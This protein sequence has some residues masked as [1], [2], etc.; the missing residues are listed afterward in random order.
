MVKGKRKLG[1]KSEEAYWS[2]LYH[3]PSFFLR[4]RNWLN[5]VLESYYYFDLR[6]VLSNVPFKKDEKILEI[7]C[8]PGGF[9]VFFHRKYGVQVEGVDYSKAG[10]AQ[11]RKTFEYA[12]IKGKVIQ[13]DFFDQA[14]QRQNRE[15]YDY[16]FSAGFIEHFE[17]VQ[18]VVDSHFSMVKRG[19]YVISTI[20]NLHYFNA[21]FMPRKLLDIHNRSI[22]NLRTMR[23]LYGKKGKIVYCGYMGGLF[24]IGAFQY[25][26]WFAEKSRFVIYFIQ[27]LTTDLIGKLLH[28]TGL[29]F[30]CRYSSPSII[31]IAQ[32]R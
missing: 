24:N 17:K 13:A 1:R 9:L 10:C 26:N 3:K 28:K 20:P 21:L 19:G 6:S 29:R 25:E 32:K 16:V 18:P 4:A 23:L 11:T 2:S 22:M 8:A 27:R 14:F 12:E 15:R 30:S 31:I 5:S 7:G